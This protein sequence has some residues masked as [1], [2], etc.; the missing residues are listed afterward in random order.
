MIEDD[1]LKYH[2]MRERCKEAHITLQIGKGILLYRDQWRMS[3]PI[4]ELNHLLNSCSVNIIKD[5]YKYLGV[6][7]III[8]YILNYYNH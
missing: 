6:N 7:L 4:S 5:R 2:E 8:E 3:I 1:S